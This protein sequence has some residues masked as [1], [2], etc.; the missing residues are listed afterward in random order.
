MGIADRNYYREDIRKRWQ[1]E[2][3]RPTP[4][5]FEQSER[6]V[7][8]LCRE[9]QVKM[10]LVLFSDRLDN[11]GALGEAGQSTIRLF[12]QHVLDSPWWKVERTIH[13][14]VAHIVVQN[15]P[16]LGDVPAHGREFRAA[17]VVVKA[18]HVSSDGGRR[19]LGF[20]R[21]SVPPEKERNAAEKKDGR[22]RTLGF[23][24][25]T[26]PPD[27]LA[28]YLRDDDESPMYPPDSETYRPR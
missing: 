23:K 1:Q 20:Q 21:P 19:A 24:P 14:E 12:T 7:A 6:L 15:T 2:A 26:T 9:L 11:E 18:I 16:G 4:A 5:R 3:Q 25:P 10:P 22:R 27:Q 13:H 28:S 17:L 8:E